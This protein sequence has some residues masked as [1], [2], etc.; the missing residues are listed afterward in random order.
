MR[1]KKEPLRQ[2]LGCR[3]KFP[4]KELLR[5]V[6]TTKDTVLDISYS[7]NG[8]GFYVCPEPP[9][10]YRALK[11]KRAD[12]V[13]S[14]DKQMTG[15]LT[16]SRV[17][18][19]SAIHRLIQVCKKMG[20]LEDLCPIKDCIPSCKIILTGKDLPVEEMRSISKSAREKGALIYTCPNEML[21]KAYII[22]GSD[23]VISDLKRHI[24]FYER[25]S[26]KG[27]MI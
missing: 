23:Q 16:Q 18:V 11:N 12:K 26:S 3:G 4:K 13:L 25:L 8:R 2:C 20:L 15:L 24:L 5:L 6:Q 10:F 19:V 17:V 7:Q 14:S 21:E 1:H 22:R 27:L 9:C